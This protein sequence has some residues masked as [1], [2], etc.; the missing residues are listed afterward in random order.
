M[1]RNMEMTVMA[2]MAKSMRWLPL[3]DVAIDDSRVRDG[4][5]H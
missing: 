5:H 3:L 1:Q 4:E 2:V